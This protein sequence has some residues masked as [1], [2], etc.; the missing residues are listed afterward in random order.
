MRLLEMGI[1]PYQ[2]TSSVSAVLNQRLIRRLCERCKARD[3]R[4]GEF[5]A[6]GCEACFNSGYRGRV[7]IAEMVQLDSDLRKAIL[8]KADLEELEGILLDKGHANMLGD[9]QRLVSEG[10]T[11]EEEVNR[12]AGGGAV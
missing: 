7:L 9:G 11:T 3:E 2:V 8:A 6:V 10:I 12:S 5:S 4:T 1:E